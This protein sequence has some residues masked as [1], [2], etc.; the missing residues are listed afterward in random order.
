MVKT[1]PTQLMITDVSITNYHRVYS[2]ESISGIQYRRDSGVQW[3]KGSITLRAYGYENVRRL[4]GFLA[5][6]KGKLNEFALPLG[7]A[8]SNPQLA[9]E[10]YLNGNHSTGNTTISF[11]YNGTAITAG[12]VFNLPNDSKLYTVVENVGGDGNYTI[13]PAL[14][15]DHVNLEQANFKAPIIT[16]LLDGNETTIEHEGNGQLASATISWSES[17]K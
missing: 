10:P 1:I 14:R 13:I 8:Y 15:T 2:T 6:L 7:G 4:N 3:F 12:S 16:A 17:L 5:S 9:V 11:T